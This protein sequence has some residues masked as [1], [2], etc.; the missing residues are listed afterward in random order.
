MHR[1][2]FL[3]TVAA[4]A[5]CLPVARP[6]HAAGSLYQRPSTDWLAKCRYGIGVH[7]TAQ[8]VPRKGSPL[9]F[10]EAVE[11]FDLKPFLDAVAHSGADYILFTACHALQMLPAPHPIIDRIL[12]GRTCKRDLIDELST[13]LAARGIPLL[14]YYN[15]SCN[16]TRT[17]LPGSRLSA[18]TPPTRTSW[19][20]T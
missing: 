9:P 17:I 13:G 10:Q 15:H 20:Q 19:R 8:T 14:V 18:T 16:S 3:T 11:A 5:A 1:R 6:S 2:R 4:G 7:W 12:P